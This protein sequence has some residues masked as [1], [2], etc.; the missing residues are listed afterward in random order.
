MKPEIFREYD[1]RGIAD[2]DLPD[3]DAELIG[4][5]YGTLIHNNGGKTVVVGKDNRESG[6]RILEALKKGILSTG[7][8]IV[9]IGEIP[10]P[11]M[12]YAVHKL[13]S[14][15]GISVTASHNPPEFNGFKVMVGKEAI[16]GAKIQELRKV[17]ESGKFV[18]GEGTIKEKFLDD[19]YLEEI[20]S[21]V[22]IGKKLKVV[23]DAGNGMASEL[24]PKLLKQLG[25][26]PICL[27]CEKD[28]SFPNHQPD[29]VQ[30][31]NVQDLKKK[32]LEEKADLGIAF[33]GDVDRVGVLDEKGTLIYGDK[34]LGIFSEDLLKRKP[35]SKIIFE[36]KCSQSLE[37]WI[38]EKGG[39]PIMW[40]TGHSLIKA[41][42]KEENA[43]LAG[44]MSG[45]MF[46]TESWYGFD[47]ALLA[48][49]KILEIV[50]HSDKNLSE[51]VGQMPQYVS[52]P[53]LRVDCPEGKKEEVVETM[54]KK[55]S[56]SNPKS[57]T[58]D[59]IRIVFDTGW[60]LVRQS[61]TQSKIILR[62]E[63]KTR[64]ELDRLINQIKPEVEKLIQE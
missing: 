28:S 44:E 45:H 17:A 59:G 6:P 30:E 31:E 26:D 10:T 51:I 34:L 4:K 58:I 22:K 56:G 7:I 55:Y 57:V 15:G 27:F 38:K 53:E 47:D 52:S 19:T 16:Y 24:A 50:S 5:A 64:E 39:I 41:K 23:I 29:P 21:N 46:F 43:V 62:F 48:A 25:I 37:E 36:V 54:I 63:A 20:V 1:I 8:N 9:F 60:A 18:Q 42:M 35:N 13:D 3:S 32:V 11:L 12:Y 2:T 49:A 33:D 40:K 61:N 14:D